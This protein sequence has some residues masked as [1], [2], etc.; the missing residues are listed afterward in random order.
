M[1]HHVAPQGR[2]YTESVAANLAG[3]RTADSGMQQ[4][5]FV[6]KSG[7]SELFLAEIARKY[8]M[9]PAHMITTTAL[10]QKRRLAPVAR[11]H[12]LVLPAFH[13]PGEM[14]P[15]LLLQF[16]RRKLRWCEGGRSDD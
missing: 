7:A 10:R 6:A 13:R 1:L 4:V 12:L 8:G 14:A 2:I 11:E 5:M 15:H 3:E 16:S 9:H